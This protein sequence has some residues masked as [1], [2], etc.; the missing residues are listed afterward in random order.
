MAWLP[1]LR[2]A[3]SALRSVARCRRMLAA[4]G[5]VPF[6]I[7]RALVASVA[8]RTAEWRPGF[9]IALD[10]MFRAQRW[11]STSAA[12]SVAS[13]CPGP[14]EQTPRTAIRRRATGRISQL[15]E[16]TA[17]QFRGHRLLTRRTTAD[18]GMALTIVRSRATGRMDHIIGRAK[19]HTTARLPATLARARAIAARLQAIVVRSPTTVEEAVQLRATAVQ[20]RAMAADRTT[21]R[22]RVTTVDL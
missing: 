21:G 7:P 17:R 5:H 19:A 16:A 15:R 14:R 20:L 8:E 10:R 4:H 1:L 6:L 11:G 3:T 22:H 18:M 13:Q 12:A 2:T 9:R